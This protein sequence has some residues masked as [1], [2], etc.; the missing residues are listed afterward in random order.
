V[1]TETSS[2]RLE[3]EPFFA[4]KR[5]AKKQGITVNSLINKIMKQ[6]VEWGA[7]APAIEL[8]PYPTQIINKLLSNHTDEE[9][10]EIGHNHAK[11]HSAENMLLLKNEESV[12]ALLAI[13]QHWAEASGFPF[14]IREKNGTTNFT[15][16]HNQGDKFSVLL[17]EII[18]TDIEELTQKRAEIK[19]TVNSVSFWI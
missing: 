11:K 1:K 5:E 17:S 2:F 14:S 4:F 15:V 12:D 9:I 13:A 10:R 3:K 7:L 19:Q 8:I 16:R 6:Y 18:K